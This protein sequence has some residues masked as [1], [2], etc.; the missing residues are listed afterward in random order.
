[1]NMNTYFLINLI[2]IRKE[3]R[4]SYFTAYPFSAN[5]KWPNCLILW[6]TNRDRENKY[7]YCLNKTN[8]FHL[9][10][11]QCGHGGTFAPVLL[12]SKRLCA[13]HGKDTAI[14]L[15]YTLLFTLMTC[16]DTYSSHHHFSALRRPG[17]FHLNRL[18]PLQCMT[19]Q[20]FVIL[21]P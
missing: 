10:A 1:M 6:K 14:Q 18:L 16:K 2:F 20:S 13:C 19:C 9:W 4:K 8:L 3:E 12:I 15:K 7:Y 17:S 21:T 5:E 11:S